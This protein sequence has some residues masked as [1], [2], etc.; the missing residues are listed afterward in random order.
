MKK[1]QNEGAVQGFD[2]AAYLEQIIQHAVMPS[3]PQTTPKVSNNIDKELAF[4]DQ[5]IDHPV[6]KG[7][8]FDQYDE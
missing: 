1:G 5:V 8:L 6:F 7:N 3:T 4:I 2:D